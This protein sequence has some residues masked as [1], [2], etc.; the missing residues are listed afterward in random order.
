M[1]DI[2]GQFPDLLELFAIGGPCPSTNYLFL[3]DYVD[4]GPYSV[5]VISLLFCLKLRYP[6]R[7]TLLR[8]N[9]ESRQTTQVYGF[10]ADCLKKY[11]SANV[12]GHV[13]SVFDTL[14]VAALVDGRMFCVH[15]GLSPS[16]HAIDQIRTL[17]R[18]QEIP[19]DG[20]LAD[21][22]WSDP[23]ADHDGFKQSTRGAGYTFGADV[24]AR[25][26]AWNGLDC[27]LRAHQLAMQGYQVLFNDQ[28]A[29]VWSAPNYCYRVGNLAAVLEIDEHHN[30]FF[31]V[32]A[33][34]PNASAPVG[35]ASAARAPAEYF[36]E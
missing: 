36:E 14:P 34:A 25:F 11:G 13:C 28:L 20:P 1:G 22:M 18:L 8:G 21:L 27:I 33:A 3:G 16:L 19:H 7:M 30:K 6:Q 23:D 26:C 15:A 17:N 4:R 24:V 9:H 29:T 32:F 12:W 35:G 10:Y 5:E 31:N 2:H